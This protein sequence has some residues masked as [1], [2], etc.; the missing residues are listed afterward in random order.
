VSGFAQKAGVTSL[1]YR[2]KGIDA[3]NSFVT[4]SDASTVDMP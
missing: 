3:D 1:Y 2:I 4:Y